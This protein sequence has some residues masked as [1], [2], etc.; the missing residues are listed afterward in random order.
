MA[1]DELLRLSGSTNNALETVTATG[2]GTGVYVRRGRNLQAV[3]RVGGA[4]T[5]TSPT[6]DVFIE[7]ATAVGGTY[8]ALA[9]F[10]Q[11]TAASAAAEAGG[12]VKYTVGFTTTKDYVRMRKTIGGTAVPTFTNLSCWIEPPAGGVAVG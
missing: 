12:D 2:N 4:I 11:L 9:Q 8:T 5:G 7:E 3:L 1:H 6:L 10:A